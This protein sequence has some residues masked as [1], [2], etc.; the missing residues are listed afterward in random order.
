MGDATI[1]F[2]GR[3]YGNCDFVMFD[4]ACGAVSPNEVRVMRGLPPFPK[5]GPGAWSDS[6]LQET[7]TVSLPS[8]GE[9]VMVRPTLWQ[10]IKG[11]ITEL[12]SWM[13]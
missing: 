2:D 8:N 9:A 11:W 5:Q 7:S 6:R 10:A 13:V 1:P 4:L 12:L 3:T